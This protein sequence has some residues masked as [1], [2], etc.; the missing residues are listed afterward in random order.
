V[1]QAGAKSASI[2]LRGANAFNGAFVNINIEGEPQP[3]YVSTNEF[4]LASENAGYNNV[5]ELNANTATTVKL[6]LLDMY[7]A[8]SNIAGATLSVEVYNSTNNLI[9]TY[10]PTVRYSGNGEITFVLSTDVSA[11]Y[12]DYNVYCTKTSGSTD[13]VVYGPLSLR[14]RRL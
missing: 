7:Q 10:I 5:L 4:R 6:Q 13:S 3:N 2:M 11:T 12:G 8:P 14:I 1:I 9:A